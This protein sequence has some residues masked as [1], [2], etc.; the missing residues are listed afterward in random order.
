M[1]STQPPLSLSLSKAA[2]DLA[3]QEGVL[4]Q[5]PDFV[6]ATGRLSLELYK[7]EIERSLRTPEYG[8]FQLLGL[9][10]SFDQG[11]AYVGMVN[12]FFE[13]KPFVTAEEFRSFCSPQVPQGN[14]RDVCEANNIDRAVLDRAQ[15]IVAAAETARMR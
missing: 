9:Q 6:N 11:A 8:G 14:E 10:D 4:S 7:E 5:V 2:R 12:N 13:P 1:N 3:K 15:R